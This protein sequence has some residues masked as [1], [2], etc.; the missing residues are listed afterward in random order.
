MFEEHNKLTKASYWLL[1]TGSL[2]GFVFMAVALPQLTWDTPWISCVILAVLSL[3]L[4]LNTYFAYLVYKRSLKALKLCL[5]LYGLQVIGFETENW[6]LSLNFRMNISVSWSFNSTEVTINLL[7][8]VIFV[9]MLLA[10]RTVRGANKS[11]NY[12][13][14]APGS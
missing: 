1:A 8:T 10:Y 11:I 12:A 3:M 5:W 13:P 2:V 6:A 9:V 7:A 4:T 14:S